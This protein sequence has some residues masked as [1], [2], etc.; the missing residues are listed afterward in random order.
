MK[1]TA[2][3]A[4]TAHK[5]AWLGLNRCPTGAVLR[6]DLLNRPGDRPTYD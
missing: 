4:A 6:L 1:A 3:Q 5:P 2:D